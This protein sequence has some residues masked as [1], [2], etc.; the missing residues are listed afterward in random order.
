[1]R[2]SVVAF[3]NLVT[4]I[5]GYPHLTSFEIVIGYWKL[6]TFQ[7]TQVNLSGLLE[8]PGMIYKSRNSQYGISRAKLRNEDLRPC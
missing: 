2:Y 7:G 5:H 3:T 1:M 4:L 6:R 8:K